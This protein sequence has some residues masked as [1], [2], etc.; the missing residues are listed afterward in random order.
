MDA[1]GLLPATC[2]AILPVPFPHKCASSTSSHPLIAGLLLQ[3]YLPIGGNPEFCRLSAQLA[4][5]SG[6]AVLREH[7]NATV[8]ALSGTGSLRVRAPVQYAFMPL[9]CLNIPYTKHIVL[10]HVPHL[11]DRCFQ[12]RGPSVPAKVGAEFL[13]KHYPGAKVVL[14]PLPTWAN[15]NKI[16]PNAGLEVRTYRYFLPSTRLLDFEVSNLGWSTTLHVPFLHMCGVMNLL[17]LS[18]PL[19]ALP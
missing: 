5:G 19:W 12:S 15:H 2:A 14:L 16:F 4:F 3:E 17:C 1:N 18:H 7:R 8:Q 6:S 13:A 9:I 10:P 11:M